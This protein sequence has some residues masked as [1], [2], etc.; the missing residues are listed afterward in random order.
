MKKKCD[1]CGRLTNRTHK[2]QGY[3]LCSKHMHQLYKY[4]KFLDNNQRT[5]TDL[6]DYE[7]KNEITRFFL[8]NQKNEKI[9]SFIIDTEDIEKVKYH[10]WRY[11]HSHVVTG[12]PAK[13]TQRDLAHIILDFNASQSD[14]VID[15]INGN[16]CDNR[17]QNLR[18]CTQGENVCN[19]SSTSNNTSGFIG[20]SFSKKKD[21]YDPEIRLQNIR[22]HLGYCQTLEEAVYKR[23][24]AE[25]LVFKEYA[26]QSE[27]QKKYEFTKDIPQ[28]LK[29]SLEDTVKKKLKA[30]NLWQ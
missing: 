5:N 15:H 19:K 9:G 22:C 14:L 28:E 29:A 18:I 30:K 12:L 26:N 27:Q 11:S 23:Y 3:T 25:Y 2:L 7:I 21:R 17:K 6:N 8:Y 16:A 20:V 13:G 4:G 10:K 1:I 24:I